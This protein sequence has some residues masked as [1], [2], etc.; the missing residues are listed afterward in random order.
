MLN[1]SIWI[2][3]VLLLSLLASL[4]AEGQVRVKPKHLYHGGIHVLSYGKETN[5][6]VLLLHGN[7]GNAGT[8]N[9]LAAIE[10]LS[11]SFHLLAVD[12]PGSGL[13]RGPA[14]P[15]IQAQAATLAGVLSL[16]RS[17][18]KAIVVG[19]SYGAPVAAQI[20]LDHPRRVESILLVAG[21]ILPGVEKVTWVHHILKWP[22]LGLFV[23]RRFIAYGAETIELDR[24]LRQLKSRWAQL[25]IPVSVLQGVD[26]A[27]ETAAANFLREVV[28]A[29]SLFVHEVSGLDH[30]VPY[31]R[32]DLVAREIQFLNALSESRK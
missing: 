15:D 1:R 7:P 21:V 13:S 27:S 6:P 19:Y 29:D 2:L 25:H 10:S 22:V 3:S 24:E 32:P 26:E 17:G 16:N 31:K 18:Q 30:L 14:Q 12:R 5:P 9:Q 23:P 4:G 8:W 11:K 28:P 20:A